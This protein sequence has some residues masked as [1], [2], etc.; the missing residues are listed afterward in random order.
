MPLSTQLPFLYLSEDE[1]R[2]RGVFTSEL[3]SPE[4]T[5]ELCPVIILNEED[6]KQIH[7]THLHD[8][9][10][11]WDI[12]K[13]TSAIALGYGSLYNHSDNNNAEFE[14]DIE[15]NLIR[16]IAI[17]PITAGEEITVD[18]KGLKEEGN[19]LWFEPE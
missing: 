16:F 15:H 10:F 5:I 7:Q 8:Y 2:G 9:Y 13:G 12:E 14:L 6:T 17:K 4:S 1:I 3:I 18:Y 11:L 19:R